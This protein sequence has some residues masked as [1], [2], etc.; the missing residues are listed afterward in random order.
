MS[1]VFVLP[2]QSG[3]ETKRKLAWGKIIWPIILLLLV[4]AVIEI[5]FALFIAPNLTIRHI[6]VKSDFGISRQRILSIAGLDGNEYYFSIDVGEIEQ[7]L[8]AYPAVKSASVTK[9]FP[10]T[11]RITLQRRV[12][13]A[14]AF[15]QADR[16]LVPA[17]FDEEGVI[18][19]L[20][21]SI[22]DWRMPVISG[23]TFKPRLGLKLPAKLMPFLR[24][25]KALRESAPELFGLISEVKVI[26]TG[27]RGYE[28]LLYPIGHDT[29]VNL[30]QRFEESLIKYSF[31]VLDVLKTQGAI[32]GVRELDFRTGEVVYKIEEK[33][34]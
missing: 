2:G 14:V 19:Q 32:N 16:R 33:E 5:L 34:E 20:D 11:L 27:E 25:L 28:L 18:F 8:A 22:T 3:G 7:R 31:M 4:L 15:A 30:G 24:D 10:D 26:S 13:L 12:P 9:V 6:E 17:A 21:A 29:R 23:L 1:E